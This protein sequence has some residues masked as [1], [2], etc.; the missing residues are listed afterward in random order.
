[1]E[2]IALLN[3]KGEKVKDIKLNENVFGVEPNKNVLYDAII[4][5][6]ASFTNLSAVTFLLAIFI[7]LLA[8]LFDYLFHFS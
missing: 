3:L 1:M 7:I 2:K 4:L 8:P 5:A 6:R